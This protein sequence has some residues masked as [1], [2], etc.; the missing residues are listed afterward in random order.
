MKFTTPINGFDYSKYIWKD[1][2]TKQA[3]VNVPALLDFTLIPW[4]NNFVKLG[5]GAYI[6][7]DT[8][9]YPNWFTGY[10]TNDPALEYI[11]TQ[12]GTPVWGYKYQATDDSYALNLYPLGVMPPF[13]NT[14]QGT[15]IRTL[16]ERLRPGQF[17]TSNVDDG[18]NIARY[19]VDP[20][21]AF[22]DVVKEFADQSYYQFW[23][24]NK[25]LYF[26]RQDTYM[27]GVTVDGSSKHFT[28]SNLKVQPTTS[29]KIINDAIVLGD[30]E[31]QNWMAEYFVG[32]GYTGKMP[33]VSSVFGSDSSVLL[34]DNFANSAI[35]SN[36]WTIYDTANQYLQVYNGYLNT[37]GGPNDGSY[38]VYLQSSQLVPIEGHLRFTHGEY[39]FVLPSDGVICGIWTQTPN[40]ALTGCL[41]G[42][43]CSKPTS[44]NGTILQPIVNGVVDTT[45]SVTTKTDCR[46]VFRTIMSV[47]EIVR[48]RDV[49][50][51]ANANGTIAWIVPYSLSDVADFQTFITE[52]NFS[53]E[54]PTLSQLG[55]YTLPA[56]TYYIRTSY[57]TPDGE[58]PASSESYIAC[59][60]NC[61]FQVA[62][63]TQHPSATGWNVYAGTAYGQET[64][65]NASPNTS[66]TTAWQLPAGGITTTGAVPPASSLGSVTNEYVWY[67]SGVSIPDTTEYAYYVPAVLNDLHVTLTGITI[68]LP[69]QVDLQIL[70]KGS[71]TWSKKLVGA[72][73]IDSMDGIAPYATI[74]ASGNGPSQKSSVLGSKNFN[75]GQAT[76]EFF[77]NSTS[78][79]TQVPQPGDIVKLRYRSAGAAIARVQNLGSIASEAAAWGDLGIRSVT[80]NNLSPL[81]RTSYEA[82]LAGACIVLNNGYPHYQGTYHCD[83]AYT[84]TAEPMPGRFILFTNLPA[85]FPSLQAE[86]ITQVVTKLSGT[87]PT[88][89]EYFEHDV[90][91]GR[92]DL[93]RQVLATFANPADV[94]IPKD[95]TE[96]PSYID[97]NSVGTTSLQDV[98]LPELV[99]WDA[100]Y[101][102]FNTNQ[103]PP[104]SG[105]FEVRYTDAGWGCDNGKNLVGRFYTRDFRVPRNVRGKLVWVRA[106]DVRNKIL[107]SEDFSKAWN[108]A[109]GTIIV[110]NKNQVGPDGNTFLISNVQFNGADIFAYEATNTSI[111]GSDGYTATFS[112]DVKGTNGDQIALGLYNEVPGSGSVCA[113]NKTFTL[114]GNWQRLSVTGTFP[115]GTTGNFTPTIESINAS[116]I[117]VFG[118]TIE[119]TRASLELSGQETIYCKTSGTAY[120]AT[121]RF[122]TGVH[123]A[124]P[125][126]PPSPTATID[127]TDIQHPM[128][129]VMLPGSTSDNSAY[130]IAGL[131]SAGPS[132]SDVWGYEIRASDNTTVLQHVDLTNASTTLSYTYDNSVKQDRNLTMYVY[133]YNLLGEYSSS[134][135]VVNIS[136]P[137]PGCSN[138]T[139]D[140]QTKT[141][142]WDISQPMGIG[143][144]QNILVELAQDAQYQYVVLSKS[145]LGSFMTLSDPDFF[146]MRYFRVTPSDKL[147]AGTIA[148]GSHEYQPAA[149]AE[150]NGNEVTTVSAPSTPVTD[151]VVPTQMQG[152]ESEYIG[153]SWRNYGLNR[154]RDF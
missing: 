113:V 79:V 136:V 86:V 133:T 42:I 120:G 97:A 20:N 139:V 111:G 115:N 93:T 23:A 3:S 63:P 143:Q 69:M 101:L 25:K 51:Y 22:S 88:L 58:T 87:S 91:F 40:A 105:G 80:K 50:P 60:A 118:L 83:S 17:D 90:T 117:G 73:E 44:G 48:R 98:W 109:N 110:T 112:V 35:D 140:E 41:Y 89:N 1:P 152:W 29:D 135:Y 47:R 149:V 125:M 116:N 55:G 34:S 30:I 10:V 147:G 68:D 114:S 12:N 33:L 137:A 8:T 71:T 127:V 145:T 32:D 66:F 27:S 54:A 121:S 4:D 78:Q 75:A 67:N 141:L 38:S 95:T 92:M 61:G 37:L 65:Q 36:N 18:I 132:L 108:R 59:A 72:N 134:A 15:I 124:F 148:T 82:E 84:T 103:D 31:P 14:T 128:I 122:S 107:W 7:V 142:S 106:F 104:S 56:K 70:P 96:V 16:A 19:V 94:Y 129:T 153:A 99:S 131:N 119:A 81:P 53:P 62:P 138:L 49:Y 46:Y 123:V 64:L 11:G 39:D 6:V 151:P 74:T 144:I 5:R 102:Y 76:L 150:F 24:N 130:G 57:I 13:L 100:D 26:K 85:Q 9:T 77:K 21:K 45:Q 52:I 146:E 154:G 2:V 28:P 126:V 43:K